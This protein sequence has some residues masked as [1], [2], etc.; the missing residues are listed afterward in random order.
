MNWETFPPLLSTILSI[1]LAIVAL[2]Y[3]SGDRMMPAFALF[4]FFF[5]LDSFGVFLY[6]VSPLEWIAKGLW[7]VPVFTSF[8]SY[9]ATLYFVLVS[10]GFI[11]RMHEKVLGIQLRLYVTIVLTFLGISV[12]LALTTDLLIHPHL[13]SSE[14]FAG[15]LGPLAGTFLVVMILLYA[16]MFALPYLALKRTKDVTRR[17]FIKRWTIGLYVFFLLAI[18]SSMIIEPTVALL[19]TVVYAGGSLTAIYLFIAIVGYHFDQLQELNRTLE[20]K[21]RE[22]TRT[23]EDAQGRLIQNEKMVAAGKLA[24]GIAHEV[25]TPIGVVASSGHTIQKAVEK[26]RLTRS[27][28]AGETATTNHETADRFLDVIRQNAESSVV[29]AKRI[30]SLIR[31]LRNFANIDEAEFQLYDLHEGLDATLDLLAPGIANHARLVREYEHVPGVP[32]YPAQ[33]NQVFHALLT[34]ALQHVEEGGSLT[35]RTRLEDLTAVVEILYDGPALPGEQ[36]S[37]MFEIDFD[38]NGETVRVDWGLAV[39]LQTVQRHGGSL[40][41]TQDRDNRQRFH[42]RLPVSG[43]SRHTTAAP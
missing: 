43:S 27:K 8:F 5:G 38:R 41:V 25:N 11:H 15:E 36:R 1:T 20:E 42:M 6:M 14:L 33:I 3:R 2:L 23:L 9:L 7:V 32:C 12:I 24:A 39:S 17:R 26:L 35:V 21:V 10:T 28:S 29:A 37:R 34:F 22:R 18:S 4:A 13:D 30:G 16:Y 31:S 19:Q 40:A